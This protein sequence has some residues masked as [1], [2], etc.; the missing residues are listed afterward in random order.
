[1]W[2]K[3]RRAILFS[4]KEFENRLAANA[5]KR[6]IRR[7][8]RSTSDASVTSRSARPVSF[9]WL[10]PLVKFLAAACIVI[11]IGVLCIFAYRAISEP[12]AKFFAGISQVK[13]PKIEIKHNAPSH[14]AQQPAAQ[15]ER[16][17]PRPTQAQQGPAYPSGLDVPDA[18]VLNS[19]PSSDS[20]S[21]SP[22]DMKMTRMILTNKATHRFYVM[23]KGDNGKW[24]VE[25][26]WFTGTGA[27]D[28]PKRT[29][30]DLKTPDGLYFIV[31]RRERSELDPK[32]GPL[33][34]ILNYP[35]E[36]DIRMGYSG[37]GIWVHGVKP[38]TVPFRSHGCLELENPNA[39]ELGTELRSGIGTPVYIVDDS[40]ITDPA[41]YPDYDKIERKRAKIIADWLAGRSAFAVL[42][43]N[44]GKAWAARDIE[45]YMSNY[46]DGF[47]GQGL[48]KRQ[49]RDHKSRIFTDQPDISVGIEGLRITEIGANTAVVK[50]VQ[51]YAAGSMKS[52]SG[53]KIE[54]IKRN[55][56]WRISRE[57]TIPE[58]QVRL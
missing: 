39:I 19:L 48:N 10:L 54:L 50:F 56:T 47:D 28:G 16:S 40:G 20:D 17:A 38:D 49:W 45:N 1:M 43:D 37:Q 35:N 25:H 7:A 26:D 6:E 42:I 55:G 46:D 9:G 57:A 3:L 41:T 31:G 30:G 14:N 24:S 8:Y 18:S 33:A 5:R 27:V 23:L 51:D 44:W 22:V 13:L 34:F 53:K 52:R 32:Y 21:V 15:Q 2:Y 12:A 29:A 58:E 4:L 11:A 36:Y